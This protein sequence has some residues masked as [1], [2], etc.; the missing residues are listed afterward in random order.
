MTSFNAETKQKYIDLAIGHRKADNIIQ[1][2]YWSK[3]G[4]GCCIGCLA[5]IGYGAHK[6]L[7]D[8]IGVPVWLS[9]V[10]DAIH[11]ALIEGEFQTWPERFISAVPTGLSDDDFTNK[12][13]APFM[14]YLLKTTLDIFDKEASPEVYKA[15]IGAIKLWEHENIGS[16]EWDKVRFDV[17]CTVY[18][19]S[20]AAFSAARRAAWGALESAADSAALSAAKSAA[21]YA[22]SSVAYYAADYA[23][24]TAV[25]AQQAAKLIEIMEGIESK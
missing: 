7:Y 6:A 8:Q 1:G 16:E 19:A 14:V 12:V 5:E 4:K 24:R 3:A 17:K 15:V 25:R 20:S 13:Q 18:T 9:H 10:A 11:E 22:A 23:A 2:E 21:Y